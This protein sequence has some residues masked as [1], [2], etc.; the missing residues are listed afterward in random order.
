MSVQQCAQ[1][2]IDGMQARQREVVMSAK[3][4]LGRWLA[5]RARLRRAHGAG[6]REEGQLAALNG[7]LAQGA[8]QSAICKRV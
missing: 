8:P 2:I 5:D 7:Q 6:R 4:K 1:L 3:G